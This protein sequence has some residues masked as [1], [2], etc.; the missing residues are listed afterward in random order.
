MNSR[1]ALNLSQALNR[2]QMV[3]GK[4]LKILKQNTN[5]IKYI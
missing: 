5:I 2:S 1:Q 4:Q 3:Y